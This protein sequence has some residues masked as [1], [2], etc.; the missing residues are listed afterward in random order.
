MTKGSPPH[1]YVRMTLDNLVACTA[2]QV[3]SLVKSLEERVN[4]TYLMEELHTVAKRIRNHA[5]LFDG[6][7][8]RFLKEGDLIKF[9]RAG[10]KTSYR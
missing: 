10:R 4:N 1:I 7:P 5:G 6:T 2:L 8:R 9:T 3:Q